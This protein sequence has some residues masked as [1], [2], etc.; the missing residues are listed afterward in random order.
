[1][2][3]TAADQPVSLSFLDNLNQL[4]V[5]LHPQTLNPKPSQVRNILGRVRKDFPGAHVKASTFDAFVE[6]LADAVAA[7]LALPVVTKEVK[8]GTV[9]QE[10]TRASPVLSQ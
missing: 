6:P 3:A 10:M 4:E 2:T 7:G 5:V 1:M 8:A 9:C